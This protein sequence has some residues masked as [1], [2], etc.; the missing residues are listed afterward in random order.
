MR[1]D[2]GRMVTNNQNQ[3]LTLLSF[4]MRGE[5]LI[6]TMIRSKNQ[7]MVRLYPASLHEY[8]L[9]STSSHG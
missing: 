1:E 7:E 8:L 6:E 4:T 3:M 9:Y 2:R 5:G